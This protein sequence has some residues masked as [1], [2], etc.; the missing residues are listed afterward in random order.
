MDY[1]CSCITQSGLEACSRIKWVCWKKRTQIIFTSKTHS[2]NACRFCQNV[3]CSIKDVSCCTICGM[4]EISRWCARLWKVSVLKLTSL[5]RKLWPKIQRTVTW[6]ARGC[7]VSQ[8]LLRWHTLLINND[9]CARIQYTLY[10]TLYAH[11]AVLKSSTVRT[12][13][14]F[15]LIETVMI[16]DSYRSCFSISY[17]QFPNSTYT[18]TTHTETPTPQPLRPWTEWSRIN[19]RWMDGVCKV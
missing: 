19:K 15:S 14:A 4:W 10:T 1:E 18:H 12:A 7:A 8:S 3:L 2:A 5:P 17:Y 9:C 13:T 16:L 6:S 11:Y